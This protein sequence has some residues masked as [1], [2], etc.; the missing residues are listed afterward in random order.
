MSNFLGEYEVAIDAKG[1]MLLPSAFRK[2]LPESNGGNFVINRG[3]EKCLTLYTTDV[4]NP[5]AKK[6]NKMN[7]LVAGV[8]DFKRLFMNGAT[9]LEMDSADRLLLPKQLL[10]YAGIKK[11]IVMA[12]QGNKVE[13]WDKDTY[14]EY[15]RQ[16]AM[17]FSTLAA[18]VA[19]D[20]GNPF[21]TDD[22]E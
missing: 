20:Y 7:D 4:W 17:K 1:R 5:I 6:I 10:E 15:M 19:K 21:D 22:N 8:R 3:F 14:Y 18:E 16:N 2:Q 12:A 9:L 11:D 13:L